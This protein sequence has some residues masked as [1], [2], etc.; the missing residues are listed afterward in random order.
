[1]PHIH[2]VTSANLVEN[3]DVPDILAA[4]VRELCAH[5]SIDPSAVKAYH[6]LHNTWAMGA[7]APSGFAHC[8]IRIESG[9]PEALR[10][11]I[12]EG[13]FACLKRLFE[14]SLQANEVALTL[15]LQEMDLRGHK[16]PG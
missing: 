1:M 9:S 7:G 10:A 11:Q 5:D 3:V 13:M 6:S 15:E 4:L 16:K 14:E 2:L 12:A 8:E